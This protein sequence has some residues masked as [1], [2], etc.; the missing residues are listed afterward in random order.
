MIKNSQAA[1]FDPETGEGIKD[2]TTPGSPEAMITAIKHEIDDFTDPSKPTKLEVPVTAWLYDE[3]FKTFLTKASRQGG[4]YMKQ[5]IMNL[6]DFVKH[7]SSPEE[8]ARNHSNMGGLVTLHDSFLSCSWATQVDYIRELTTPVDLISGF[9]ARILPLF[10]AV[11]APEDENIKVN[12][13]PEYHEFYDNLWRR[14]RNRGYNKL[15]WTPEAVNWMRT[16]TTFKHFDQMKKRHSILSRLRHTTHRIAF[17]LAVNES[18]PAVDRRHYELAGDFVLKYIVPCYG[19]LVAAAKANEVRDVADEVLEYVREYFA[20][21][22]EWPT[23][24]EVT[25]RRFWRNAP[26]NVQHVTRASLVSNHQLA[27]VDLR[28]KGTRRKKIAI[29]VEGDYLG[30]AGQDGTTYDGEMFYANA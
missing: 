19:H 14:I 18:S 6:Y 25:Q 11:R 30:Y 21:S 29:V 13:D 8:S 3:E 26:P 1:R 20:R 5:R 28:Y 22:G 27:L 24:R 2:F 9:F 17:L 7:S 23:W 12:W 15:P 10:G 4:D 16:A